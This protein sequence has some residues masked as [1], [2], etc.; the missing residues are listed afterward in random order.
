MCFD[1]GGEGEE[2]TA[3]FVEEAREI[4]MQE[5]DRGDQ[6]TTVVVVLCCLVM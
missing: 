2:G 4:E 5:R 1:V 3:S 6:G